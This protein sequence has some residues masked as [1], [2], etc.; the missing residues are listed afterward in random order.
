MPP[1]TATENKANSNPAISKKTQ[2]TV[3]LLAAGKGQR[4]QQSCADKNQAI[5]IKQLANINDI[6]LINHSINQLRPLAKQNK[7]ICNIYVVLGEN[8][9]KIKTVL[10]DDVNVLFAENYALGMGHTIADSVTSAAENSSHILIALADQ[11]LINTSHYHQLISNSLAEPEKIIATL[12]TEKLMAPAIFPKKY[13]TELMALQGDKGAGAM[14]KK[15]AIQVISVAYPSAKFDIDT[16]ADLEHISQLIKST[17]LNSLS[18]TH[19]Q[20]LESV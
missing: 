12:S 5:Q 13:F 11:A 6:P 15:N 10:P 1:N 18:T 2:L 14:L 16:L 9:E 4:F 19:C 3:V 17:P 7:I 8:Q 20:N